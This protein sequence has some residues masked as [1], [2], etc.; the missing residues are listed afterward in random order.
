MRTLTFALALAGA[1]LLGGATAQEGEVVE[2][3]MVSEGGAFYF[4]PI[5]VRVEPGTT[6]RFVASTAGHNAVAYA[7]A[8]G[9]P[10]RIPE[11][12]EAWAS[13]ILTE[14][15]ATFDVVVTEEGVYDYVCTPHE[16]LGMVGRV[17]V[18]DP[19]AFPARDGAEL[20]FAAAADALPSV[21]AILADEDGLL[22][23]QEATGD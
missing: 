10:Q 23:W 14:L 3:R 9:L 4:D 21:E 22:T 12:A 15:G 20:T 19:E 11:E 17:V 1:L 16:A 8:N 7:E 13:P 2:I 5:G 18:G 6:L